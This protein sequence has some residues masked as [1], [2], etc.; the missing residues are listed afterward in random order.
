VIR[1]TGTAQD[2]IDPGAC[3][4]VGRLRGPLALTDFQEAK[5]VVHAIPPL[6][7]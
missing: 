1:H 5:T 2:G 3:C 7:D 4:G 6:Q